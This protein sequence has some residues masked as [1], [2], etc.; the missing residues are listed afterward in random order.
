[1]G[2]KRIKKPSKTKKYVY[3]VNIMSQ[4]WQS[5]KW[6][7][8][9]TGWN[10]WSLPH[11]INKHTTDCRPR[12]DIWL[13]FTSKFIFE[14]LHQWFPNFFSIAYLLAAYFHKLYPSY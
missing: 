4:T 5:C 11:C 12:F 1:M 3:Y 6:N 9:N 10:R 13:L 8:V 14:A 7:Y 2:T